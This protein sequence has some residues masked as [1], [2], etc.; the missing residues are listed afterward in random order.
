[1]AR[2]QRISYTDVLRDHGVEGRG[3]MDC[4]DAVY[5]RL[6]DGKAYELRNQRGLPRKSNLR[7][8]FNIGELSFV[9][10]A[11]ALSSERIAEEEKQG[12]AECVTASAKSA[13]AI[14]RAIEE[15]RRSRQ[16]RL[17]VG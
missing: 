5:Q 12:N 3:Y 7:D 15:D 10:A 9:M 8:N 17:G 2:A 13:S 1:M 4:T 16:R 11:E 14:R 6:F